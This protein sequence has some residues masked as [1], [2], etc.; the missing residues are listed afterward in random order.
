MPDLPIVHHPDYEAS[1]FPQSHRFPM[2]KF[3]LLPEVL[4]REGLAAPGTFLLPEPAT[5]E[6]LYR[7][8]DPAYVDAVMSASVS[9]DV[10]RMI[11]LPMT[12]S[13]G[14][15]G[16]TATGGT[17]L[18]AVLAMEHGLACNT[19]GGSHHA[20]RKHG[21]GFCVFNDV[22]VAVADLLARGVA[23]RVLVFDC[24]VHQGDGTADIF[25]TDPRVVTVSLHGEN[26]YPALKQ[27][28]V[29]DVPLADG[30]DDADYMSVLRQT[31]KTADRLGPYDLVF[32]NAGVD[33]HAEDLLGR[34]ALTDD[35]LAE[36]DRTVIRHFRGQGLPV[37]GVIGGGYMK[38]HLAVARRHAIL[39]RVAAQFLQER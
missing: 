36:R 6:M 10:E 39:H 20:G 26:N 27:N 14:L 7:V 13:V 32:Y 31:L 24:D 11:G 34:L 16:A 37:C 9:R 21:A 33:P 17:V 19:A 5:P 8:H 3:R 25:R 18:A 12:P 28:S 30:L 15:R 29:L 23:Q 4:M 35:G 2:A 1:D 22:A 38:D